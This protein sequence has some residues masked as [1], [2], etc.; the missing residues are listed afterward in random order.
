MQTIQT[1]KMMIKLK[2]VLSKQSKTKART[3][4]TEVKITA[5]GTRVRSVGGPLDWPVAYERMP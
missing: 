2:A 5:R 3:K 4:T 1:Q